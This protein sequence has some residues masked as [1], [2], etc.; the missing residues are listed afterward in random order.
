MNSE[1]VRAGFW[2]RCWAAI[3]DFV[4]LAI[5]LV[6]VGGGGELAGVSGAASGDATKWNY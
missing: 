3:I 5:I 6:F 1:K 2:I 4:I